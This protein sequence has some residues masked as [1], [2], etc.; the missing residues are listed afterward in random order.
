MLGQEK[1]SDYVLAELF[2]E[3][4]GLELG[5]GLFEPEPSFTYLGESLYV[6]VPAT[7]R[8]VPHRTFDPTC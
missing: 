8:I 6:L 4:N 7:R 2:G 1:S 3:P 5:K